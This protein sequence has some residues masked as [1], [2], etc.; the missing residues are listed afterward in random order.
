MKRMGRV[1]LVA[2]GLFLGCA[3]SEEPARSSPRVR[4]VPEAAG[5]RCA[6][7]G[8]AVQIGLDTNGN[9]ELDA[10][11]IEGTSYACNGASTSVRTEVD[12]VAAGDT[13]CPN[14]GTVLRLFEEPSG[15]VREVVACHG[16][17]GAPGAAG[18]NGDAGPKGDKG[19]PGVK[20]DPGDAG[21]PAPQPVFGRF[22]ASQI[23]R[24]ALLTC[25]TTDLST[26]EA[27]C[28]GMKLN[29]LDI[30]LRP[31]EAHAVCAAVTGKSFATARGDG[32]VT[33]PFMVWSTATGWALDT[34]ST[35]APMQALNCLR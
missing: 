30:R 23:V 27:R 20:G 11:E 12:V 32:I 28:T 34:T 24:G 22:L 1:G 35:T 21:A 2:V 26:T 29:G 4:V 8:Q 14:G 33:A 9:G 5:A 19:D 6:A 31:D 3:S 7:G 25:A 18:A 16:A 17:E 15:A 13:R 10:D